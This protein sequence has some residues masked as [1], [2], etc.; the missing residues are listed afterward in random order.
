MNTDAIDEATLWLADALL[1][2]ECGDSDALVL[3][4]IKA[5]SSDRPL[6]KVLAEFD[7][8][9][10]EQAGEFGLDHAAM[11]VAPL[12]LPA[13]YGFVKRFVAKFVE[14]AAGEA[15]KLTAAYVKETVGK[16]LGG[17]LTSVPSS[18]V[19]AELEKSFASR[20]KELGL[21]PT[22]Y[23]RYLRELHRDGALLL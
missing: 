22:S 19:M 21:P 17:K 5:D 13:L 14:G 6:K 18:E 16:A 3:A 2:K 10:K 12:V 9:H 15:G 7:K 4:Q 20:A 23:E 8:E 11:L 1:G